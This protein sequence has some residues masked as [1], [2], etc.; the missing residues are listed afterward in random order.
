MEIKNNKNFF[1]KIENEEI[2][3]YTVNVS[4][5][6]RKVKVNTVF[7]DSRE[8]NFLEFENLKLQIKKNI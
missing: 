7:S 5:H 4:S 2:G 6:R 3:V 1:E 8:N